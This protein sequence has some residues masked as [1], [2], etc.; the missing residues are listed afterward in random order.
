MAFLLC[1]D[2][3]SIFLTSEAEELVEVIVWQFLDRQL[4][5]LAVVMYNCMRSA[6]AYFS[7][8]EWN[9]SCAKIANSLACRLLPSTRFL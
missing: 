4:Q 1:R 6:L 7:A 2:R 9:T 5:G 3:Q 8:D